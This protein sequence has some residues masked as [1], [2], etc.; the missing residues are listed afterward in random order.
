MCDSFEQFFESLPE[1][2]QIA[3]RYVAEGG[4]D[5]KGLFSTLAQ[6]EEVRDLDVKNERDQEMIIQ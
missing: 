6:V 4:T 5:M 3:A 1:E 2:L